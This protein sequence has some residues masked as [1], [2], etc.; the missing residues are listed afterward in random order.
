MVLRCGPD[1][2]VLALLPKPAECRIR[3]RLQTMARWR[4]SHPLP[5]APESFIARDTT[6]SVSSRVRGG[7][8]PVGHG[9]FAVAVS[10]PGLK[11]LLQDLLIGDAAVK[12]LG[13]E[14]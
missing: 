6:S 3:S 4:P 13:G 11:F 8:L 1:S 14:E 7:E 9:V 12:T 2:F 10:Y 5:L